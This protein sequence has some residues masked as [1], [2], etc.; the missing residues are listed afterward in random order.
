MKLR[1]RPVVVLPI[2]L[3]MTLLSCDQQPESPSSVLS[4][5]GVPIHYEVHGSGAPTLVFVHGWACD[6]SYWE[7]QVPF[8]SERFRVVTVDL[9]GHGESGQNREEWTIAAFGEDVAAVVD[10]LGL[11]SAVLVGHSMGAAVIVEA[12]RRVADRV[13]GLVVV[14]DFNNLDYR[15]APG[16]V[17]TF[18]ARFAE[19]FVGS[20][21]RLVSTA[22]FLPESDSNLVK[23]IAENMATAAPDM[24]IAAIRNRILWFERAAD[25][26]LREIH[27]PIKAINSDQN[28]TNTE[29]TDRYGIEVTTMSGVGHF[30]MMEDPETFNRLLGEI[31][32]EYAGRS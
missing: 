26:A 5:D 1:R 3:A 4:S 15:M 28:P 27:V 11:E 2:L 7:T 6:R 21:R 23:R 10:D 13:I 16:Q 12:A 31:V 32:E 18:L 8:F 20:T 24:G 22:M 29:A 19:D 9:A 25:D 30:V 17:E 14:D